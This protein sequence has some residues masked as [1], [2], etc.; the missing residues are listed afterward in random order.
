MH[1]I[2][3]VILLRTIVGVSL[4]TL[5]L[6]CKHTER[7]QGVDFVHQAVT[8][9]QDKATDNSLQGFDFVY[10]AATPDID[11]YV[12]CLNTALSYSF[13]V[14]ES[15]ESNQESLEEVASDCTQHLNLPRFFCDEY[16]LKDYG[17]RSCTVF[18]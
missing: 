5:L 6:G 11:A 3:L 10:K 18:D 1:S 15:C 17:Y 9:L 12:N 13:D 16:E 2:F 4:V 8:E 14:D 7:S